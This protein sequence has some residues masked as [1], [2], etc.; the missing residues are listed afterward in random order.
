MTSS[1]HGLV[2][3]VCYNNFARV[4]SGRAGDTSASSGN[5]YQFTSTPQIRLLAGGQV[6]GRN[7]G[8]RQQNGA[9]FLD[10]TCRKLNRFLR[11]LAAAGM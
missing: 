3:L 4:A 7:L 8:I 1:A 5:A 9:A 11:G 6:D 2:M 10:T